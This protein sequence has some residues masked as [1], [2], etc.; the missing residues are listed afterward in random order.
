MSPE[1]RPAGPKMTAQE[2][3]IALFVP[4]ILGILVM[5]LT[6][7]P[8]WGLLTFLL[9]GLPVNALLLWRRGWDI[10]GNRKGG[11]GRA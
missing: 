4:L 1:P 3:M 10:G 8:L 7:N 9:A 5:W 11:S 6:R 2:R